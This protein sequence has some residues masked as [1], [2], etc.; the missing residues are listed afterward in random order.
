MTLNFTI[1]IQGGIVNITLGGQSVGGQAATP[2]QPAQQNTQLGTVLATRSLGAQPVQ[3]K[4]GAAANSAS[5]DPGGA[6]GSGVLVIGP[7]VV[8]AGCGSGVA[9]AAA[10]DG[11]AAA[12]KIQ[13][14]SDPPPVAEV[15]HK[16]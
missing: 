16:K 12:A 13:T 3:P 4:A 6:P 8:T 9:Q 7:I 11:A 10:Q 1:T 15:A 14:V 2:A 5:I